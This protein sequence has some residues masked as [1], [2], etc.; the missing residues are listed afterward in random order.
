MVII[1]NIVIIDVIH[2]RVSGEVVVSVVPMVTLRGWL[3]LLGDP[4][5]GLDLLPYRARR[6]R[7][8]EV[9]GEEAVLTVLDAVQPATLSVLVILHARYC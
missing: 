6:Q 8:H 1:L 5:D 9:A 4:G 3:L 7:V 2:R